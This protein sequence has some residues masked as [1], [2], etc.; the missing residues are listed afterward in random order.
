MDKLEVP[1]NLGKISNE[2][3]GQLLRLCENENEKNVEKLDHVMK[4]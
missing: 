2:I 1:I 3:Y 4:Y